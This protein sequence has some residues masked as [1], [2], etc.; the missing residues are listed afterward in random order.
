M[1][2]KR[3]VGCARR[4]GEG[5]GG[6]GAYEGWV[7]QSLGSRD[8]KEPLCLLIC[9]LQHICFLY[10]PHQR[11]PFGS[12]TAKDTNLAQGVSAQLGG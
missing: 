9:H 1:Q 3:L 2:T 8:S 10:S 11:Q 4:A 12:Q 6:G 7:F 5:E